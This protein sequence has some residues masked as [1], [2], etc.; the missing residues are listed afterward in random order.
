LCLRDLYRT[1]ETPSANRLR[2][3]HA[4]LHSTV[5]AAYG[6]KDS[7]D[8]LAFLLKLNLRLAARESADEFITMQASPLLA[9][10]ERVL[11]PVIVSIT[12]D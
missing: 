12:I 2:D 11:R 8:T 10:A 5:R 4:A 9:P 7:E 3:T 1:L 6:L